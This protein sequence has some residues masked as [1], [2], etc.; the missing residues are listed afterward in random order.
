MPGIGSMNE[1]TESETRH[2]GR[3]LK[4]PLPRRTPKPLSNRYPPGERA[5][6]R[7]NCRSHR[8]SFNSIISWST[9]HPAC[10]HI[11]SRSRG[12]R[13][14]SRIVRNKNNVKNYYQTC[15]REV[16]HGKPDVRTIEDN[17]STLSSKNPAPFFENHVEGF[18]GNPFC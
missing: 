11:L 6:V 10:G 17:R 3:Q 13:D 2:E 4:S 15:F 1:R 8:H 14:F 16:P 9:P 5:R 18:S 12:R 7:G